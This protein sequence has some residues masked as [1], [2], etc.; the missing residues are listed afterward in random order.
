MC[1]ISNCN[2]NC[3][4]LYSS[5]EPVTPTFGCILGLYPGLVQTVVECLNVNMQL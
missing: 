5:L 1:Y 4:K 2:S 3:L